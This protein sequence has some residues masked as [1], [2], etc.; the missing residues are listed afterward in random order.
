[1]LLITGA[2]GSGRTT[3]A[4]ASAVSAAHD[5]LRTLLLSGDEPATLEAVLGMPDG[6]VRDARTGAAAGDGGPAPVPGTDGRLHVARTGS[7]EHFRA[8]AVSLQ[9]RGS[10]LLSMLGSVPLDEDELTE[11]PGSGAF[12]LLSAVR[13]AHDA[14]EWDAVVVDLPHTPAAL[15]TLALPAQLRRYLRRLLPAERQAARALRP[16]LAQLVGI[17]M[18]TDALYEGA[19]RWDDGLAAVQGLLETPGTAV[20]LVAEPGPLASEA[21]R[22][23]RAG[24]G[25]YGL[26]LEAVVANRVFPSGSRDAWTASLSGRQ[27]TVLKAWHEEY[28]AEGVPVRELPHLGREPRGADDLLRLAGEAAVGD[29]RSVG[30]AGPGTG[31]SPGGP[32]GADGTVEDRLASDGLLVWRLALPAV[33]KEELELVRRGDELILGFGPYR[34]VLPLPSALRRC[35]VVGAALERGELRVRCEPDPA[36]WPGGTGGSEGSDDSTGSGGAAGS[37]GTDA[38]GG[39]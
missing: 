24:L 3:V 13:A 11:L 10:K 6:S 37:A 28:G 17:P 20:L 5:G 19:A 9:E 1:M 36:L 30:A 26:P 2:G 15:R 39:P 18:P 16:A 35:R 33:R 27:Q 32:L 31:R 14:G 7:A 4:A 34:R 12:S 38:S 29:V 8:A 23:G 22:L 25:L 21:L